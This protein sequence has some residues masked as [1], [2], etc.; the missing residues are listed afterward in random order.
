MIMIR[1]GNHV[2]MQKIGGDHL[3]ICRVA[4]KQKILIEKLRFEVDG[5]INQPFGLFEVGI[6]GCIVLIV[7]F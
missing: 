2:V 1:V 5:A 4:K 3:R 6:T 7:P